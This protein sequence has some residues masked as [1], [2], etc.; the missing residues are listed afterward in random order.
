MPTP[1]EA[2]SEVLQ[3]TVEV[4]TYHRPES[5]YSVLKLTPEA[6]YSD[7]GS[8]AMFRET[9]LV[10]V[11]TMPDPIEGQRLKL[12]GRWASHPSHG[13][14]FEFEGF[15]VLAPADAEG[16]V[17][18]LSSRA[19]DGIGEVLAR[20]IVESVGANALEVIRDRPEE[21]A[22]VR[23]LKPAARASLAAAVRREFATHQLHAFLR[24]A[25]LG[26]RQAAAV[27]RQLGADCEADL[28][29]DPYLLAGKVA[30]IGFAVADRFAQRLGLALDAPERC[31][32]A[33]MHALRASSGDGHSLQHQSE[34][35]AAARELIGV[36]VADGAL[37]RAL[38]DLAAVR[39]VRVEALPGL[40]EPCVYLPWLAASEP[41]VS[42]SVEALLARADA[43]PA[44]ASASDLRSME[45]LQGVQLD[46]KQHEAVLGLLA[47]PLA[48]LTGGPGVGKTTIVRWVVRLAEARAAKVLLASPTGRAAKRLA[49]ATGSEAS[50]VHRLLGWDPAAGSFLH[51]AANPLECDLLVVDEISMLDVVLAHHLLKAVAP[52]TRLVLVGDP[53]QLPS[54]G[55]GNVLGDLI[56]SGRIPVHRL[57]EVYRQQ[58]G[59]L[60]VEN[61][62]RILL[63]QEPRFPARGDLSSDFYF[64][65]AEDAAS[66][67]QRVVEVVTQRIPQS[68]GFQWIDDVQVLAPM[69]RGDC[70]VDALN[71]RLRAAL[72]SGGREVVHGGRTWRTGD[73]VVHTRNDYEREVFNG[74][75]GRVTRVDE[76]G[77]VLV[78]FPEKEVLYAVEELG[79]LQAAFAMTVHR[80][81]GSEYPAVVVP[82]V[83]AHSLMLQRNL[84]YTAITRARKL[85]V[86][87]GSR[88]ALQV[89]I[90]NSEPSL[91][92]SALAARLG[93]TKSARQAVS[94]RE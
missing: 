72:A 9:R 94:E 29:R 49:E 35:F 5:L 41:G 52:P 28:R 74:D 11:G 76:D 44:L 39:D 25:G 15:E 60:I 57:T 37:L 45:T 86:L 53:D 65:P 12:F 22:R 1:E 33:L 90:E 51:D 38:D 30:G 91:R 18:Y 56:A 34:L 4:V 14:Q 71:E 55:P 8:R 17:R 32:G 50:T 73:R 75:M 26:P 66:A 82:L 92:R 81:Q 19:F 83:M 3:G 6:G 27:V 16:L 84:L 59:S 42:A 88:R 80:S 2:P 43:T 69:Y 68:F 31:R 24:G 54:V 93:W 23:G 58:G 7:P 36:P 70:G 77:S 47:A 79:D 48:L 64:F 67:A 87:V 78:R 46:P 10:A 61:A 21:L 13:R 40:G 89:A 62:H 85:L 20:R 63:G